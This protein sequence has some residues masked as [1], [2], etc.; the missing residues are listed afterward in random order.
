M[1]IPFYDWRVWLRALI[2][3]VALLLIFD[4]L[5]IMLRPFDAIQPLSLYSTLLPSRTRLILPVG[6][7]ANYQLMPLETLL[8]AHEVSRT[9][10]PDEFRVI[11]L[12]DSGINGWGNVDSQTISGMLTAS[13]YRL[14]GKRL[15]TYN[16]AFLGPSAARDLLIADAALAYQPDLVI[17]F[18]TLESF[19]DK[20]TDLLIALNQ[21]RMTRLTERFGLSDVNARTFGHSTDA[22]WQHSIFVERSMIYRWLQFQSMALQTSQLLGVTQTVIGEPIPAQPVM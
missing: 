21:P 19:Q 18:V 7:D 8:K 3:G 13:G 17:A 14:G 2:K 1:R 11:V 15:T 9:K 12:G 20:D 10:A 22:W 4:M 5:F 6:G 16:L